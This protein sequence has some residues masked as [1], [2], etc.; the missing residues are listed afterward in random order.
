[1]TWSHGGTLELFDGL[2]YPANASF[3]ITTIQFKTEKG[4][5]LV[6]YRKI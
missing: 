1:M 3:W 5:A 4:K 6:R 2:R